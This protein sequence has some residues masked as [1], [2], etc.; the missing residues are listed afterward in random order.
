MLGVFEQAADA[1]YFGQVR[2]FACRPAAWGIFL[3]AIFVSRTAYDW[4]AAVRTFT[5]FAPR[6][7]VT[8]F[9][10]IATLLVIGASSALR[11]QSLGAGIV[12]TASA[13]VVSAILCAVA[14]TIMYVGW[15][16]PALRNA[17]G[18]GGGL[19]EV[20]LLP[21]MLIVP[22]TIVGAIGASIASLARPPKRST[23]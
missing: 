3:A 11:S 22:G 7:E 4:F 9:M 2:R 17:V 20:Y 23:D 6:A 15:E 10:L 1:R 19:S 8:T 5:N 12:A 21:I 13:L 14:S 18:A 16:S